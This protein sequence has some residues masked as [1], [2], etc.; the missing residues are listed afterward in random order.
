[1]PVAA[2][3]HRQ[4]LM[5]GAA[6]VHPLAGDRQQPARLDGGEG[7]ASRRQQVA[8]AMAEARALSGASRARRVTATTERWRKAA[9][10]GSRS[11]GCLTVVSE[12]MAPSLLIW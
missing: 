1:M 10:N 2:Q 8:A 11:A 5:G 4:E 9:R 12:D 3:A 7:A 6:L